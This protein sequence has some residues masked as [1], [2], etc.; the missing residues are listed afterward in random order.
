MTTLQLLW[1]VIGLNAAAIAAYYTI[2]TLEQR[3]LRTSVTPVF[4]R[5]RGQHAITAFLDAAAI[6]GVLTALGG[7][8]HLT[9]FLPETVLYS[10]TTVFA[11]GMAYMFRTLSQLL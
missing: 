2:V 7:T 1:G 9:S 11:F 8:G 10:N 5:W 4:N 6:A 3:L